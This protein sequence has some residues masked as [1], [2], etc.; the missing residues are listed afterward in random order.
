[1]HGHFIYDIYIIYDIIH[2]Y[3][4]SYEKFFTECNVTLPI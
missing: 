2:V 1:M 3:G 4:Y